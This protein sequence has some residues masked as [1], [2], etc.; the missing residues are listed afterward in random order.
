MDF[1][2]DAWFAN[3]ARKLVGKPLVNQVD[4]ALGY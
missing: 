3:L 4:R 1:L 2:C